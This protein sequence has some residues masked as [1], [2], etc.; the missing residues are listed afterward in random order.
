MKIKPSLPPLISIKK[1][2][3][4]DIDQTLVFSSQSELDKYD[5]SFTM[6]YKKSQI[7]VYT[8]NRFGLESFL[9]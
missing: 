2:L 7:K 4:L 9:F 6:P 3:V 8:K 5:F 1:T